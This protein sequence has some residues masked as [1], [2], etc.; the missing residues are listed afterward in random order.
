M[1]WFF[2]KVGEQ[3]NQSEPLLVH[4][5]ITR[6]GSSSV[7]FALRRYCNALGLKWANFDPALPRVDDDCRY[8]FIEHPY[9]IHI[10]IKRECIYFTT[11]RNPIKRLISH[12]WWLRSTD[13]RMQMP[14]D[15]YIMTLPASHNEMARWLVRL[16]D[17]FISP[18]N[19]KAPEVFNND[20]RDFFSYVPDD[21]LYDAAVEV[22][23]DKIV[24][25]GILEKINDFIFALV[26][27]FDWK[28]IPILGVRVNHS[29]K[30]KI[31]SLD[32]L[33]GSLKEKMQNCTNVDQKLYRYV[34]AR[35][36]KIEPSLTRKYGELMGNY[37]TLSKQFHDNHLKHQGL[38]LQGE[39]VVAD[40]NNPK[41]LDLDIGWAAQ[42]GKL[43]KIDDWLPVL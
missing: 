33:D 17:K 6:T 18:L 1:E 30:P 31:W 16:N 9:P 11:L 12:Y 20:D 29:I 10:S 21:E 26:D 42:T 4:Y 32:Q 24:V 37:K 27:Y 14:I 28:I 39:D 3:V 34:Q 8:L 36:L 25:V 19:M 43:I 41:D 7:R 40:S 15:D 13:S 5:G 35:C 38:K 23:N 22:I 2:F